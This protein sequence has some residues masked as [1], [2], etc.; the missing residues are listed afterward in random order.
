MCSQ[1]QHE[2]QFARH[3]RHRRLPRSYRGR[4]FCW[5]G[6]RLGRFS[7]VTRGV[8]EDYLTPLVTGVAGGHDVDLRALS[9]ATVIWATGYRVAFD[10]VRCP[11]LDAAFLAEAIDARN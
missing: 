8:P 9:I 6:Q 1:R 4:D 7:A 10:W 3:R 5:W 11:V 2:Y